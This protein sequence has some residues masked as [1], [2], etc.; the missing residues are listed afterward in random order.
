M[1]T[2][3]HHNEYQNHSGGLDIRITGSY[4]MGW[5]PIT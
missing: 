5:F 4:Q 2:C 1:E 3:R